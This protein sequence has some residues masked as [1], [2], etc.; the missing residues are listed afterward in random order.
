MPYSQ[1]VPS[2]WS[3]KRVTSSRRRRS[4]RTASST[5]ISKRSTSADEVMRT[6]ERARYGDGD[7][8]PHRPGGHRPRALQALLPRGLRLQVLVRDPAARRSHGEAE[9]AEAT[10]R[11]DGVLPHARRFCARA[12]AL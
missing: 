3:G 4:S 12:D 8:Q 9:L 2:I 10:A 11:Y 5:W 1:P 7:V 6:V